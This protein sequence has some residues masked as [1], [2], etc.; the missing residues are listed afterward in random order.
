MEVLIFV[1]ERIIVYSPL[2]A[3]VIAVTWYYG[4][5]F[6]AKMFKTDTGP[7][8][9]YGA[10]G[11]VATLWDYSRAARDEYLAAPVWLLLFMAV[12]GWVTWTAVCRVM[13]TVLKKR[14]R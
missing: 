9:L 5:P 10:L 13:M 1:A 11:S 8:T 4:K 7:S 12:V 2:A 6:F 3:I 14:E